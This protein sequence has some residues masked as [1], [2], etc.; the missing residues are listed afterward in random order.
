MSR[1]SNVQD[2]VI[3]AEA[4]REDLM[5]YETWMSWPMFTN[6]PGEEP[7]DDEDEDEEFDEEEDLDEADSGN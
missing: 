5:Q 3:V 6:E 2:T 4:A 1:L 7:A